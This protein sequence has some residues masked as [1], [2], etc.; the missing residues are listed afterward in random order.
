VVHPT[1]PV[2]DN[3]RRFITK[4]IKSLFP[5][6]NSDYNKPIIT[7]EYN[8]PFCR[9]LLI[10]NETEQS[11]ATWRAILKYAPYDL[12]LTCQSLEEVRANGNRDQISFDKALGK[13]PG[14]LPLPFEQ[15]RH[16]T[17]THQ[18]V[19]SRISRYPVKDQIRVQILKIWQVDFVGMAGLAWGA[20]NRYAE[21]IIERVVKE[22]LNERYDAIDWSKQINSHART[23]IGSR[24]NATG[25][26][27]S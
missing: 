6:K 23:C 17:P 10:K 1:H 18:I 11:V 20:G 13:N 2:V 7:K 26:T 14:Q 25:R 3:V 19:L 15:T 24:H 22:L 9:L 16:P 8:S 4:V 5:N 21:I 27:S 12:L